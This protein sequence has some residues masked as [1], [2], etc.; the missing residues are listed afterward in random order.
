MCYEPHTTTWKGEDEFNDK[1]DEVPA[2]ACDALYVRRH[3]KPEMT[4]TISLGRGEGG[5]GNLCALK[6][7][8]RCYFTGEILHLLDPNATGQIRWHPRLSWTP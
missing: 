7:A 4:G 3:T 2:E 1:Q 5:G 8:S 6:I